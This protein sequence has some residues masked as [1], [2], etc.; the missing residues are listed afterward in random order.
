MESNRT[1]ITSISQP[2]NA[3]IISHKTLLKSVL[4]EIIYAFVGWE[5]EVILRKC[6]VLQQDL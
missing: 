4:C 5:I 3:H 2:T 6:T 1:L